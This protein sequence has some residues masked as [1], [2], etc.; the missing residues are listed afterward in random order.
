MVATSKIE[1]KDFDIN[2]GHELV[3]K[4]STLHSMH[5]EC[6]GQSNYSLKQDMPS[7]WSTQ[8]YKKGFSLVRIDQCLLLMR[9]Q[10]P[11]LPKSLD[12]HSPYGPWQ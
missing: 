3:E 6:T 12:V 5:I 8:S 10:V 11:E 9:R 2:N 1:M 4:V 7:T